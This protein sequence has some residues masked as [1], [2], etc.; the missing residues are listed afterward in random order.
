MLDFS[1]SLKQK[2]LNFLLYQ[3]QSL[4]GIKNIKEQTYVN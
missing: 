3:I 2:N 4:N 1:S